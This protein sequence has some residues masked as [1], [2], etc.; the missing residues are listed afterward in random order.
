MLSLG[1]FA[2]AAPWA[3]V[4]L[5]GLPLLWWLLRVT[6]PAPKLLRFPA[7]RLLF[8]L[9]QDEQTPARTPLWLILLRMAIVT[10]VIVGL[11]RPVLNPVDQFAAAGPLV[12]VVDDGWAAA[13]GWPQRV[14]AM[15]ALIA[16]AQRA[17]KPV[18]VVTTAPP[19]TGGPLTPSKLL[20]AGAARS[21]V[22]ALQP[23][24]WPVARDKALAA[25]EDLKFDNPANVMW[26]TDGIEDGNA[27]DFV[28]SLTF[29]GPVTVMDDAPGKGAL[30]L[31]PPGTTAGR[32]TGRLIRPK[33]GKAE[34]FWLRGTDERGRV[35]LRQRIEFTAGARTART[36]LPLP[37]EL[38]N[39]LTRL[40]VEG[41]AS[42]GTV[43][44]LDERWRRRPVGIVTAA[45][46]KA[47]TRPLLSEIFY[48][49]RALGPYA[50]LRKGPA[51]TLLARRLA[52]LV[53]ADGSILTPP[54]R[55]AVEDWMARGGTVLRFAGPRL[56]QKP[57]SL[58]PVALR[59][60]NR[61]LGGAMSW[62]KPARLAPFTADSPFAGL[63]VPKDVVVFR[64]VLAQPTLDLP[65]RT[66][67]RLA[68]G[69]PLVTAVDKGRGRLILVHT[70]ANTEWSNLA[71]SGLF[72]EILRR[73]VSL[74][75]GVSGAHRR[76]LP[77]VTSLDGFG[78]FTDPPPAAQPLAADADANAETG[79]PG[80]PGAGPARPRVGP[81]RP[82]GFYGNDTARVALNLA[83]GIKQLTP[84]GDLPAG[85]KTLAM[86][87]PKET[88]LKAVLLAFALGLLILDLWIGLILR[89]LAPEFWPF[90]RAPGEGDAASARAALAAA[91][92]AFAAAAAL[93][94]F[95]AGPAHAQGKASS[96]TDAQA[97]DATFDTRLAYVRT[98]DS[99][100]DEVS[101]AGLIGLSQTLRT[102]T[103]V[104]PKAPLS[105]D[106]ERDELTFFPFLYWPI[107]A[108]QPLPSRAARDKLASYLR[109]GG[110][111]LFDTRDQG[112]G[113]LGMPEGL[114]PSAPRAV[115]LRR[116]V[117]GL[118]V[119]AL[120]PVPR[121]HI[122]TKAFY[123]L[124]TFPGRWTGGQVWVEKEAGHANDGVSSVIIGSN[125]FAAAW[126]VDG[127]GQPLY[128]VVPGGSRQREMAHRFGVNLVMYA[129]TGNYKSDQVHVPAI[130][131]RLGQ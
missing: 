125:D 129:L 52:V 8:G 94:V 106:L 97:M 72:V 58:T 12:L 62:T 55:Q 53:V 118:Q 32:L 104:E 22:Q 9:R 33:A 76:A 24:P 35:L 6:P 83:A 78:R 51:R 64:Q 48:L 91:M 109:T 126:A 27:K 18:I 61:A 112:S 29:L 10:L 110:M 87:A 131:E 99:R 73:V 3:L 43:A 81:T 95:A 67:A 103:S 41:I 88:D 79:A 70:T 1:P 5:A 102:R 92:M 74:S 31:P 121:G 84:I 123:L 107:T 127:A 89:G 114:V 39:R 68:D 116:I 54:D 96:V 17:G 46:D 30:A 16:R 59:A 100:V 36:V 19:A 80:K 65:N 115:K 44:L 130:L 20:T 69:T 26:I 38:R 117:E 57:D 71:I 28:N 124:K 56:G 2:F 21:L 7:I 86:A 42:A 11:A 37:S 25:L 120:I 63:T 128:P 4:A 101:R 14:A 122:L 85:V 98:G 82:P 45:T 66:W 13:R 47:Q 93:A 50:E 75:Q 40:E 105:V 77:P 15:D 108:A 119:P 113:G 90:L 34:A 23:K 60:G 111:I 49:D